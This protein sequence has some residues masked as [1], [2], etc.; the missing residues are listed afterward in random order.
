MP[1]LGE[2]CSQL[3]PESVATVAVQLIEPRPVLKMVN[4]CGGVA[5]PCATAVKLIPLWEIRIT[6]L[7][8]ETESVTATLAVTPAPVIEIVPA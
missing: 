7:L 8:L 2:I 4:V 3:P 6:A 5:P 1:L